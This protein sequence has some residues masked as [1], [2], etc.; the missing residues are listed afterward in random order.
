MKRYYK[1]KTNSLKTQLIKYSYHLG[2]ALSSLKKPYKEC[3]IIDHGGGSGLLG[4]LAKE[5][6][7]NKVIYND[8][9]AVFTNDAQTIAN[10]LGLESDHYVPGNFSDL[11]NFINI[12]SIICDAIISYNVI[13]HIYD[14]KG[15]LKNCILLM[16]IHWS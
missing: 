1:G 2:L 14:I 7:V 4:L 9:D 10:E 5:L 13:E 11:F 15:S 8:I 6:G 12:N 16:R 3:V